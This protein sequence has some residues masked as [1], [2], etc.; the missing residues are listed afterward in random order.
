MYREKYGTFKAYV[1]ERHE[2]QKRHAYKVM[3]ATKVMDNL[4][5][6]PHGAH[7]PANERQCRELVCV[8]QDDLPKV[9]NDV[10]DH[11]EEKEIPITA[12]LIR[13]FT[14]PYRETA[15]RFHECVLQLRNSN[16]AQLN[17]EKNVHRVEAGFLV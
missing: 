14:G 8:T 2:L 12:K 13:S 4:I 16:V 11:A 1:S 15:F 5:K 10:C 17:I 3:D 9:W 6:V 7:L